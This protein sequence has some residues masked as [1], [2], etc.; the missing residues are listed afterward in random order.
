MQETT[1]SRM[2]HIIPKFFS[3]HHFAP[4]FFPLGFIGS[5]CASHE[6]PFHFNP[7]S[8]HLSALTESSEPGTPKKYGIVIVM[9]IHCRDAGEKIYEAIDSIPLSCL[10]TGNRGFDR[11]KRSTRCPFA[12]TILFV[13]LKITFPQIRSLVVHLNLF[14]KVVLV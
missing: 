8:K 4:L 6:K 14:D 7:A 2:D 3:P 1:G 10:V 5:I 11:I 12:T 9:K 13:Q